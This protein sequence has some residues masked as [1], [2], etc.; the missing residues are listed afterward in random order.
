MSARDLPNLITALRIVLVAPILWFLL[1]ES[2]REALVL[3]FVAGFSDALD[4]LLAKQFGWTSRLGAMLDPLADKLLLIGT[5]VVLGLLGQLPAWLVVLVILRDVVIVAGAAAYHYLI[6]PLEASPLLISKLNTLAQLTLVLAVI[7]ANAV[8]ALPWWL[9]ELL[10]LATA[11]TTVASGAA[12]VW[13][14]GRRAL[15]KGR[16]VDVE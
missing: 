10:I 5:I 15:H 16:R 13:Q 11:L 14:W 8:A 1:H 3:F 2:Y 6:E 4:G 9:R 7:F 12:Y